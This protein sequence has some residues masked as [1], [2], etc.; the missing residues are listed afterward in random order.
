M[1]DSYLSPGQV[2]IDVGIM[3]M[4]SNLRAT[5]TLKQLKNSGCHYPVPGGVGTVNNKVIVKH[6]IEAAKR[7]K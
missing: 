4:M 2:V 5:W 6:V 3:W 7:L 1:V